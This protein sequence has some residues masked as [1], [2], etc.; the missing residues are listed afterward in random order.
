MASLLSR[1]PQPNPSLISLATTASCTT[2]ISTV[3]TFHTG[4]A[5]AR[6]FIYLDSSYF[7]SRYLEFSYLDLYYLDFRN[8]D[9]V[10]TEQYTQSGGFV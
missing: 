8:P 4:K 2:H 6:D 3:T 7:D 10:N 5:E 1:A 9:S